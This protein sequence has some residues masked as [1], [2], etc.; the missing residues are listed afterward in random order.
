MNY[1]LLPI[2]FILVSFPSAFA[3]IATTID[4][5]DEAIAGP[6]QPDSILWGLDV[7]IDQLSMI[8]ADPTTGER[9][10]LGLVIANERL[11]EMKIS[12]EENRLNDANEVRIE[13]ENVLFE[14]KNS[15]AEID[16]EDNE[17]EFKIQIE[18]E[19]RLDSHQNKIEEV[20]KEIEVKIKGQVTK[21]QLDYIDAVF[22]ILDDR[23]GEIEIEIK[24]GII[25]IEIELRTEGL[26]SADIDIL[27]DQIRGDTKAQIVIENG[28]YD[29]GSS[30]DDD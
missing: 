3:Q 22:N 27:E 25:E 30:D 14:I 29:S 15:L 19:E 12:I 24:N 8:L 18:L 28:S 5:I 1:A 10:R 2:L 21:E 4:P 9:Q 26:T 7:A 6:I 17:T 23:V 11:H 16:N 13:H 20:E